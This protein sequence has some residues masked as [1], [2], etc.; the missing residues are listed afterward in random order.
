[1]RRLSRQNLLLAAGV[2]LLAGL[3]WLVVQQEKA[4][5]PAPL[6]TLAPEQIE[7]FSV[8]A[9]ERAV[10]R[11]ER[12]EGRWWMQEPYRLPAQADA[13]QRL[14]AVATA[15]P[16]A[17]HAAARF[18]PA[19]I[20]LQPPQAV[21]EFGDQ[22]IAFG[23]T[24]ALHGD[25]YVQTGDGIALLPDRYSAWLLAPAES[26]IERRLAAPLAQVSEVRVAGAAVPALAAAWDRVATGQVRAAA[27]I[28]APA[29]AVAVELG[30]SQGS[31]VRYALWRDAEGRYLALRAEPALLYP[32]E[33][34]QM[35]FL[36]PAAGA[37]A[38]TAPS[39]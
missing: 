26:E 30:D 20:G 11:F 36:L 25:R 24:D 16:R 6:T 7:R 29:Q 14:L 19:R 34:A 22:Q 15:R 37:G 12:R 10:R 38:V 17:R 27:D 28:A 21:L 13:V 32:L 18:D 1:M 8:R 2:A 35:Q 4:A 33:E 23:T 9:G 31:L 5:A 39:R 3:A